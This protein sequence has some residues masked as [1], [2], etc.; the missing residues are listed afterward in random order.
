MV[1]IPRIV[2]VDPTGIIA[3]IVRSA[4]ELLDLSVIQTD[5]PYTT[6]ALS[7]INPRVNLVVTAM[8]LDADMKGFEFALRVK[9]NAEATSVIILADVNDPEE[10]DDDTA[11]NSPFV[12]LRRPLDIHRFLRVLVAG[13]E[14][15]DAMIA[16]AHTRAEEDVPG[17]DMGAVPKID[18]AAAK[19]VLEKLQSELNSM[20]IILADRTGVSLLEV[21]TTQFIDRNELARSLVPMMQANMGMREIVGGQVNSIQFYD[22]DNYDVF[23]LSVGLHHFISVVFEGEQGARQFGFVNRFGRKAVEDLI[24]II[25]AS[26]F[27]IIPAITAAPRE[28]LPKRQTITAKAI[29]LDQ[30]L[31]LARAEIHFDE[32]KAAPE[33]EVPLL[34]PLADLNLDDLFGGDGLEVDESLFDFDKLEEVVKESDTQFR[35]G[36]L[37]W[38]DAKDL[39]VLKD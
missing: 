8:S 31:E 10:L 17:D 13:L 6:D 33:P 2:T 23:V 30:P 38:D 3:R 5:I 12:Y 9:Q 11:L 29:E 36:R 19:K 16:A 20:A 35:K 14:G 34:E 25:G 32:E 39:G 1:S 7:E 15:H 22:G 24:G 37:T 28:E 21:G 26:A 18:S 4:L 27:F